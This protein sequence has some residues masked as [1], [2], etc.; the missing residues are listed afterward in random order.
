MTLCFDP[1]FFDPSFFAVCF[2]PPI[3]GMQYGR[4]EDYGKKESEEEL[5]LMMYYG[6]MI[7]N[8]N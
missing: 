2:V 1:D 7:E 5:I 6:Y 3:G 4:V 8:N